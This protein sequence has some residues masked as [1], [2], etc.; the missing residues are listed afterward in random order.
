MTH[1]LAERLRQLAEE[2]GIA[3]P[4]RLTVSARLSS[5][6]A[7]GGSE[8]AVP[9]AVLTE[10]DPEQQRGML[11][12]E[13]AHLERRDPAWLIAAA[14]AE[15]IGFFQPLNRL[16]R[17]RIQESAE[18]LCDEWAVRQTGS[19][20]V[21]AKCLAK[22]AEW[23]DAA[24]TAIPV[25]GM[26]EERSHLM[27]RVRRLLD[28][29]PFPLGPRPGTVALLASLGVLGFTLAAPGVSLAGPRD[30]G[31][32]DPAPAGEERSGTERQAVA[33]TSR[34]VL[35]ALMEASR[36]SDAEVRKAALQSLS[37]FEDPQTVGVFR[38]ALKDGDPEIRRIGVQAL[39]ELKDR[40]SV[41]AIAALLKDE[42]TE[43][44]RTAA[45]ALAEL[46]AG[47]ARAEL[48]AALKDGD[49]EVR[50]NV[51]RALAEL[52]DPS[53]ADA[54][55]GA[56][57]D[58]RAEVRARAIQALQ[59][60]ELADPPAAI[61]DALRDPSAEV[62][63]RAAEAAGHFQDARAI[64]QLRALI[65]DPDQEVREA[66]VDALAEI[67]TEAAIDAL[68]SALKSRDPKVRRAAA[69]ALGRK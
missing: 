62:R 42:N 19:G 14:L 31:A 46:P 34:A 55:I 58:P 41:S 48:V 69:D 52:K 60:L 11:A 16:A 30:A 2:A 49:A 23:I 21:L 6:V 13:L 67:R 57:K 61:L 51:I 37:R 28:S 35:R 1:P 4:I 22:V 66:A 5:P 59:E 36:D 64:P 43:L 20:V 63:H 27:A 8:I 56:L 45:D 39:A 38:E 25:A 7:L 3:R 33:D 26:A 68:V 50:A 44:R 54:L 10:L 40:S 24:P 47:G 18:Y 32:R 17:R 9:E 53:M 15:R 12:H 65:V 29:A